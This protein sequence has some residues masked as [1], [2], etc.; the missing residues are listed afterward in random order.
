MTKLR[1]F[2]NMYTCGWNQA[3]VAPD[4]EENYISAVLTISSSKLPKINLDFYTEL[5]I[6]H[7][8]G[9]IADLKDAALEEAALRI[10]RI[11]NHFVS[12]D[13]RILIRSN[14]DSGISFSMIFYLIWA[15]YHNNDGTRKEKIKKPDTSITTRAIN[16]IKAHRIE[17]DLD[18][19]L[20]QKLYAYENRINGSANH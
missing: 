16:E 18:I 15:Y 2:N 9:S 14:E 6:Q 11:I 10:A 17:T 13:Q 1:G 3:L 19:G 8:T 7:Y 20:T 12:N 5:G 4:L